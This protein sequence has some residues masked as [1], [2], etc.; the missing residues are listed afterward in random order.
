M[1]ANMLRTYLSATISISDLT[2][3]GA[4]KIFD[5]LKGES[6]IILKNNKPVAAL[7]STERYQELLEK[8]ENLQLM[9]I[10]MERSKSNDDTITRTEFFKENGIDA[11]LLGNLPDIEME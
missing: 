5:S 6:K 10:A 4:K 2:R 1:N 9:Q 8:E 11:E 3:T 7:L